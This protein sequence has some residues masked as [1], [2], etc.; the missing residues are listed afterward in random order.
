MLRSPTIVSSDARVYE[1]C[2]T[3][4]MTAHCWSAPSPFAVFRTCVKAARLGPTETSYHD[5]YQSPGMLMGMSSCH[6]PPLYQAGSFG[7]R[8]FIPPPVAAGIS[9][10][11][12]PCG[13]S[14]AFM[15]S[16][17]GRCQ[18]AVD[19]SI[20]GS[21]CARSKAFDARIRSACDVPGGNIGRTWFCSPYNQVMNSICT[22][23]PRYQLP[24]SKYGP[25]RPIPAP[26][27]CTFMAANAGCPVEATAGWY[28]A[29]DEQPVV[30]ALPFD[31]ACFEIQSI[32][33]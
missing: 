4:A 20:G 19:Q 33:S 28:S 27:P 10:A 9:S 23:P 13:P 30:P 21:C 16:C 7:A 29:V 26:N 17:S 32:K 6:S 25:T 15:M 3:G 11:K 8:W 18:S 24:C 2:A 14:T 22:A 5:M 1:Q 12:I 31:H